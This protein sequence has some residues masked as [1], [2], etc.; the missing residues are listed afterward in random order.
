ME[1]EQEEEDELHVLHVS[2]VTDVRPSD[3]LKIYYM[4]DVCVYI[5]MYEVCCV[6]PA[7]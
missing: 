3:S 6:H 7:L 5:C 1:T 4:C 2:R